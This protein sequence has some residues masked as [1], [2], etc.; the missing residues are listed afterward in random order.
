MYIYTNT[1]NHPPARSATEIASLDGA[2]GSLG[3]AGDATPSSC[4]KPMAQQEPDHH[5]A[6]EKERQQDGARGV[7]IQQSFNLQV[8]IEE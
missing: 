7:H 4:Q 1:L 6:A 3:A 2:A 5:D 8:F